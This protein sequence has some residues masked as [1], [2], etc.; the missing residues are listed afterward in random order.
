MRVCGQCG[1][2]SPD[3]ARFC[4]A[5]GKNLA[6]PAAPAPKPCQT[7]GA[8]NAPEASFCTQCGAALSAS[9]A[10]AS[11]PA[12]V[13]GGDPLPNGALVPESDPG[14]ATTGGD[15][16]PSGAPATKSDPA[17][18]IGGNPVDGAPA[19]TSAQAAAPGPVVDI[20]LSSFSIGKPA[21]G[22][23]YAGLLAMI[24]GWM[25][26]LFILAMTG[27][28][29]LAAVLF[30]AS[31]AGVGVLFYRNVVQAASSS[32]TGLKAPFLAPGKAAAIAPGFDRPVG[33]ILQALQVFR[34]EDRGST[35]EEAAQAQAEAAAHRAQARLY[36][37]AGVAGFAVGLTIC[38]LIGFGG[39]IVGLLFVIFLFGM[40]TRARRVELR[41][42]EA[43]MRVDHRAPILFLRSFKDDTIVLA[44]RVR[45][46]ALNTDQ[47][48]RFEEAL[49]FMV[50][51][52]GP[53]LA[54]GEPGEGLPQLGAAR[55]Y[56]PD[57]KW[58][59]AVQAWIAQSRMI[60]ML[61]GPTRWVHWEMQNIVSAGRLEQLLLFLP[62]GR[63]PQTQ[64]TR[65]RIERWE[66][67]VKSLE[68]T[69][70]GP[71]MRALNI[72]DVLM[73]LFRP[74][75]VLHVFRSS[76]D[77]VQ[78]YELAANLA[79]FTVLVPPAAA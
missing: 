40:L 78:D 23:N 5:C 74:G 17:P 30:L 10:T 9:A 2:Q 33:D 26:L 69:A 14:P 70:Y 77:R 11:D 68:A 39:A 8:V 56:L 29:P 59:A 35:P 20:D 22:P 36:R 3:G 27:L 4:Q 46:F 53:F 38:L 71:A 75:G 32:T 6:R 67:I 61:C 65:R 62:P 19:T 7:C 63:K 42:A 25:G 18:D 44:Q 47:V 21:G 60:A 41:S 16:P 76:G 66:N 54:V 12:T 13:T 79:I 64:A 45:L 58:Q 49:G 43:V 31:L 48:I 37:V 52:F 72:D 51:D 28:G 24:G 57:D 1:A 34:N 50:G 15:P 55:A 73:I